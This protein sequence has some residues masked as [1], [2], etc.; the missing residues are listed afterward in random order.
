MKVKAGYDCKKESS[1]GLFLTD[2]SIPQL[3]FSNLQH[4]VYL[5]KDGI[6]FEVLAAGAGRDK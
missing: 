2:F 5:K 4:R 3:P 1:V 6:D